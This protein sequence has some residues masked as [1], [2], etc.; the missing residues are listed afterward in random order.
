[1]LRHI[2]IHTCHQQIS[3]PTY[4]EVVSTVHSIYISFISLIEKDNFMEFVIAMRYMGS[5]TISSLVR[6]ARPE[7][8]KAAPRSASDA[9]D[10]DGLSESDICSRRLEKI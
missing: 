3:S 6:K 5:S 8:L 4:N 9:S 2:D 10:I 1:M 7:K